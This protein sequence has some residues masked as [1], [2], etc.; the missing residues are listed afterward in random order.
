ML[1]FFS[2]SLSL[3][4]PLLCPAHPVQIRIVFKRYLERRPSLVDDPIR[5]RFSILIR[6]LFT[7]TTNRL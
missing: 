7:I 1:P 5:A 6:W 2:F 4:L 3:S